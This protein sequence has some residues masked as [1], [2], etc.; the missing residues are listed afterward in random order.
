MSV[1]CEHSLVSCDFEGKKDFVV[2]TCVSSDSIFTWLLARVSGVD[3]GMVM[4]I[5][6]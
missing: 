5:G 4:L 3:L 2:N 6:R 1:I